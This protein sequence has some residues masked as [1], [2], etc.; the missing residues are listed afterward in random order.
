MNIILKK[1]IY[2]KDPNWSGYF[3]NLNESYRQMM[4]KNFD[5]LKITDMNEILEYIEK[6]NKKISESILQLQLK[7]ANK[8]VKIIT[9]YYLKF[10]YFLFLMMLILKQRPL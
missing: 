4:K 6:Q 7:S 1:Q 9:G 2:E 10:F 5:L 3:F 8:S